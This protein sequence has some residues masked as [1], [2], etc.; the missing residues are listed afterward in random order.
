MYEVGRAGGYVSQQMW[1][2][3]A[4]GI[5]YGAAAAVLAVVALGSL[6]GVV[7]TGV[8]PLRALA[9]VVGVAAAGGSWYA[10]A[11]SRRT[12]R[13]AGQAAIGAR[14]ERE[15][16]AVIRRTGSIAVAY[17]IKLGDRGGDCDAV[18]FTEGCGAAAVE[19]KTGHG[20]VTVDGDTMRVGRRV[21]PKNPTGQAVHQARRLSRALGRKPV[22]AIVCVPGMT[23][24]AFATA[25]GVWVCS[26]DDL[27]TVLDRVPRVFGS[28][29]EAQETMK[30]L[31]NKYNS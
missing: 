19:V 6:V 20:E 15:V 7:Y 3:R 25:T 23:N 27:K 11:R 12:L 5:L 17:G 26:A 9:A 29:A 2:R 21:L 16:R 28:T 10:W 4:T 31:W 8:A 30:R 18:V 14:S 1:R 13:Q 22:L 24:R